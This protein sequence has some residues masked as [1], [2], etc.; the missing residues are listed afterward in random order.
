[1]KT[2]PLLLILSVLTVVL[3]LR[4]SYSPSEALIE[5]PE[6]VK[7]VIDQK[8][9]KC[10]SD[11]GQSDDAKKALHWDKLPNLDKTKLIAT[12]DEISEVLDEGTMPPEKIVKKYPNMKMSKEETKIL[13]AWAENTAEK[14]LE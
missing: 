5:Y 1:M 3:F 10:H 6:D 12:L 7:K 8:C 14:L 13:T 11:D 2:F 4:A 9:Y